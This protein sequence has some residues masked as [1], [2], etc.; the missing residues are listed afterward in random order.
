MSDLRIDGFNKIGDFS[1]MGGFQKTGS[2]YGV[3][4]PGPGGHRRECQ[5]CKNRKYKDGSDEMVSFKTPSIF[6]PR[7]LLL[8]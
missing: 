5:T 1:Q 8:P 3:K 4:L 2:V 7:R 6:H